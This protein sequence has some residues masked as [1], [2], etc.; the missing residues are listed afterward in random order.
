MKGL[1]VYKVN[2]IDLNGITSQLREFRHI[3]DSE[4]D[5]LK[6]EMTEKGFL[7]FDFHEE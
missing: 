5:R 7:V 3:P 1:I 2:R 4:A 6:S